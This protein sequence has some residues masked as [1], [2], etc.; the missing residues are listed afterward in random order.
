MRFCDLGK[1][2]QLRI[3][4]FLASLFTAWKKSLAFILKGLIF[5]LLTFCS[6]WR[7]VTSRK[8]ILVFSVIFC[9]DKSYKLICSMHGTNE[10]L[11]NRII[12]IPYLS[13]CY[14]THRSL[15]HQ[16]TYSFQSLCSSQRLSLMS[17]Y[18]RK[19]CLSLWFYFIFHTVSP[20]MSSVNFV[21]SPTGEK[22]K[23]SYVS[24]P[25]VDS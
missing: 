17:S 20:L 4:C 24:K 6:D 19:Y 14:S 9:C 15:F 2:R 18:K 21:H 3:M 16:P 23:P 1:P 10:F 12:I 8:V 7:L 5:S 11:H 25:S 22:V 13:R